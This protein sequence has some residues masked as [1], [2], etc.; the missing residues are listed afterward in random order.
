MSDTSNSFSKSF[1]ERV[2]N[3]LNNHTQV[4]QDVTASLFNILER[5][6]EALDEVCFIVKETFQAQVLMK[7]K[8]TDEFFEE[9]RKL[10][11]DVDV[12]K[13]QLEIT[14]SDREENNC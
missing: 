3:L 2:A 12:L 10:Q 1:S 4:N 13:K 7:K 11:R 5:E 9:K 6:N 8:K 14:G